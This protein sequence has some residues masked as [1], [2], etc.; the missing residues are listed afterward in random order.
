MFVV[1]GYKVNNLKDVPK[2]ILK[3]DTTLRREYRS[4]S[5][6]LFFT[7]LFLLFL[8]GLY[9]ICMFLGDNSASF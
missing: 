5:V 4:Y 1:N 3:E 9:P 6:R 8:F 2:D 7:R